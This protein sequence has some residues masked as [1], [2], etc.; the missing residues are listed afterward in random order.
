MYGDFLTFCSRWFI[1]VL[2]VLSS[3]DFSKLKPLKMSF[4]STT[5]PKL[6]VNVNVRKT[7][8]EDLGL[9]CSHAHTSYMIENSLFHKFS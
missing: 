4:G 6:F 3:A 8:P 5:R 2:H 9:T 7:P 1:S